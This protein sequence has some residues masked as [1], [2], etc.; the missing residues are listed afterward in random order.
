MQSPERDTLIL[1]KKLCAR[2]VW[3]RVRVLGLGSGPGLGLGL[4]LGLGRQGCNRVH[5]L[6]A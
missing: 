3:F 2:P 4:G 6:V 5:D 1:S